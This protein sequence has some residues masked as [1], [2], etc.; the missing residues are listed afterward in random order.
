MRHLIALCA[1]LILIIPA[2]PVQGGAPPIRRGLFEI[3]AFGG[4]ALPLADLNDIANLGYDVGLHAL[5]YV[6]DTWGV[7]FDVAYNRFTKDT[8]VEG[9]RSD[10]EIYEFTAVGKYLLVRG[11]S[12]NSWYLKGAL[13]VFKGEG[14]LRGEITLPGEDQP[15]SA[16]YEFLSDERFGFG[17]GLGA[18]LRFSNSWGGLIETTYQF[19]DGFDFDAQYVLL[20]G[21]LTFFWGGR[22]YR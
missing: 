10:V 1:A 14:Q 20:R 2:P 4:L 19:A 5:I 21:G 11:D 17:L 9:I 6:G 13:G 8:D 12:G 22:H 16:R 15:T 3:S 18:Q 7:G